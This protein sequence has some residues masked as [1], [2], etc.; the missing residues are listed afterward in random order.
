MTRTLPAL[1]A[2]A[3]L[4][5]GAPARQPAASHVRAAQTA[6]DRYV[7]APDPSYAWSVSKTLPA[8]EGTTAT[9]IDLTSQR[10]LDAE[11]EQPLWKHWLVVVTPAK[12]TSDMA[13]LFVGGGRNDRNPPAAP[14]PWQAEI[15]RDTGTVVAELRMVPNQPIVFKNDPAKKP[16]TEDDFIAYTWNQFL[17]TGDDRWPA[18]LPMTKSAVRAMDTVTAFAASPAGGG[19]PVARFVVSGASKRGWTSWAAAAVDTRVA[20]LAPAVIDV[21]NVEPSF[22]HHY[23]AYGRYSDAVDDYVEQG[24]MDWLGTPQFRALMKIEEPYE[25]RDRLT[26]PKLL[27]NSAGDQFFLPDS[28]QFYFDKLRGEN[29]LRYVPNTDHS[30]S[31]SDALET[32]AAFYGSMVKGTPRPEFSWTFEKDGAIKVVSKTRPDAVTMWEAANPDARDFRL[33]TIGAV[34]RS[35]A[36]TPSGP[37][38]WVARVPKPARGWTAFFVELTFASGGRYPLKFT[39]AVRVLPD[40][41]PF[42]APVPKRPGSGR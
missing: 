35:T 3:L 14:A 34:Y 39:T 25:Y 19:H 8:P 5:A 23:R 33:E 11:I 20:A 9:L 31:K 13:L 17:R 29:H 1:L 24:I 32:L 42:A 6:L 15:A 28:S 12:V 37:N 36:L 16:R 26:M 40:T 38:T 30:L 21:L 7:A 41:L 10:W 22:E 18:R 27:L 2:L 4:G